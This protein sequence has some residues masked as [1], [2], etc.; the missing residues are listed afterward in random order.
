M[1]KRKKN[2]VRSYMLGSIFGGLCGVAG[3][4]LMQPGTQAKV[5]TMYQKQREKLTEKAPKLSQH[6][7]ELGEEWAEDLIGNTGENKKDKT[8]SVD[9]GKLIQTVLDKEDWKKR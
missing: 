2:Y 8:D 3:A 6:L 7:L 4:L 9:V 1:F 5:K